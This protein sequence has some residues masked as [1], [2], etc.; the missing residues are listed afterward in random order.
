LYGW[1]LNPFDRAHPVRGYFNDPRI[2]GSSR[3][4]H[5]GIDISA[6]NGTPVYAV[7]AGV[8]HLEGGRSLSVA[9]GALSF[10]YWHVI[11]AVSHLQQVAQHQ[12]LGHVESPWLHLHFAEHHGGDYRDPLRPGALTP[13]ADTTKPEVTKVVLSRNGRPL[14]PAA[15]SGAVDV[16]AEAHQMPPL[17]VPAPWQNLPVTPAQ[18]RWRVLRGTEPVRPWHTPIDFSN[19]LLPQ[20][21][22][23]WIYAPGTRQNRPGKPGLYRFYLAHTWT[24]TL[25]PDDAYHLE[26]EASDLYNNKGS[27]QLPFTLANDL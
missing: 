12:L 3:A 10:G 23:P 20:S 18:I 14:A 15:I 11:P 16:I 26:V 19:G 21:S 4:F 22:F 13:W 24:T 1:P 7:Q 9:D 25:L 2:A 6:A 5:F 17:P 27:R 8:V